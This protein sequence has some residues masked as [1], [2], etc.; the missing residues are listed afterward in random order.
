MDWRK[1]PQSRKLVRGKRVMSFKAMRIKKGGQIQERVIWEIKTAS[2]GGWI[3]EMR[4][5]EPQ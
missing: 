1:R 4:E 5:K 2:L 3:W